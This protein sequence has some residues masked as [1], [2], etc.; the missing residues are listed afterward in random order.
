M[1][2]VTVYICDM[3]QESKAT[4]WKHSNKLN[5]DIGTCKAC[6]AYMWVQATRESQK[7]SEFKE[8]SYSQKI[9]ERDGSCLIHDELVD[10]VARKCELREKATMRD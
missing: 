10:I 4:L 2:Y 7:F 1:P 5:R 8:S 6:D 9:F 3:C